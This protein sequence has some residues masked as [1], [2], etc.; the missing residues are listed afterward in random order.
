MSENQ[1]THL[2]DNG[3]PVMGSMTLPSPTRKGAGKPIHLLT[4]KKV[5]LVG[6]WNIRTMFQA[7]KAAVIAN[8]M[9]HY[10]L[11]VLGFSETRCEW[12]HL[13]TALSSTFE[14]A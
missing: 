14:E 7:G 6:T 13:K 8:E 9:A 10:N 1:T 11:S 3:A 12:E 5:I 2:V 4:P